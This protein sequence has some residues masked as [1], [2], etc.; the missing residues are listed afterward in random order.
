M[1]NIGILSIKM[2]SQ[3]MHTIILP[4]IIWKEIESNNQPLEINQLLKWYNLIVFV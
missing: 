4:E 1:A 2:M 3:Y